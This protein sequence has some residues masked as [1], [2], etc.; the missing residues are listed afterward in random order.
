MLP[1]DLAWATASAWA[2]RGAGRAGPAGWLAGVLIAAAS[3]GLTFDV[4]WV[5]QV[6]GLLLSLYVLM[7]LW[8]ALMLYHTVDQAGGVRAMALWRRWP[9]LFWRRLCM[10]RPR[11]RWGMI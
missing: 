4:W 6:K 3:F 2:A 11:W 5:S 10:A 8:P 1:A 7:V 9:R